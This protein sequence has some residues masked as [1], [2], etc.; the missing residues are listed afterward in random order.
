[1]SSGRPRE[2]GVSAGRVAVI[3]GVGRAGQVGEAIARRFAAEGWR[4]VLLDRDAAELE[5]RT[6]DL[7]AAGADVWARPLDLTSEAAV[8][9]AARDATAATAGPT[10]PAVHALVCAAGGFAFSGP[11]ADAPLAGISEQVGIS[12]LT[13]AAATRAFLPAL[14]AGGGAIT[15][16][17]S[18]SVLDGGRSAGMSAYA[19][20]KAGVLAL[21][22]T[23]A[24]EE[25]ADGTR[26]GVRAN[27]VAPTAIRTAANVAAMGA[28]AA[29]VERDTVADAVHWLS[30]TPSVTGQVLRL[31]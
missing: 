27:A 16:F 6:R 11:V 26:L 8:L 21:M 20:A 19:I 12:V 5:A 31:G 13:A 23:I 1:M 4:L 17:A 10:G 30:V 22:R 9:D 7:A 29:Y 28:D 18:A 15:Y 14:R 24:Q 25:A 3:T 2:G